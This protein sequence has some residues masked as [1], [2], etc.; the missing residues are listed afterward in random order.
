MTDIQLKLD[1]ID[2]FY[3]QSQVHFGISLAVPRGEIVCLLGGN[4][5][6]KSTAMKVILG[7]HKARAGDV[8]FEGKSLKGLSTAH[9]IRRGVA[10]VPEARRLFGDAGERYPYIVA[11][12]GN[13]GAPDRAKAE[14]FCEQRIFNGSGA[15]RQPEIIGQH[16]PFLTAPSCR[17]PR[18]RA[19][20]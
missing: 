17:H 1:S 3:G 4:A 12:G 15:G 2:T 14:L 7:L 10:S 8:V 19:R 5:S 13:L 20:R 6:G 18:T 9:I 16:G 11:E